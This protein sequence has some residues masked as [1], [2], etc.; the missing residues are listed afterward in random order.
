MGKVG[1]EHSD[2]YP[3]AG[4]RGC[5]KFE[6]VWNDNRITSDRKITPLYGCNPKKED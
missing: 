3:L 1:W 2:L 4:C 6:C 5:D